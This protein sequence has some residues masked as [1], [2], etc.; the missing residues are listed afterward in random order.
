MEQPPETSADEE[1][2]QELEEAPLMERLQLF[3]T[4]IGLPLTAGGLAGLQ[5][6]IDE[7]PKAVDATK[8]G[9][10]PSDISPLCAAYPQLETWGQKLLMVQ[11]TDQHAVPSMREMWQDVL[12]V[13]RIVPKADSHRTVAR[14]LAR[15]EGDDKAW[16]K[17]WADVLLTRREARRRA[18]QS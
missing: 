18:A 4:Q 7:D 17:Y 9:V 3:L 13:P 10:Q 6:V 16:E 14:A 8:P 11:L 12:W 1:A 5:A 2:T 15:L